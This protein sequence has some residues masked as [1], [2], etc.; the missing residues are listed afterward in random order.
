[1]DNKENNLREKSGKVASIVGI[2]ANIFLAVGKIIVGTIF[3]FMSVLADGLNNLSDCGSSVVSLISFKLSSKP[4]DEE[5]PYGHE[6]IEYISSMIV[7]FLILLIAFELIMEAVGKII[8]P[9]KIEFSYIIIAVLVTSIIIKGLMFLYYRIVTK[10]INSELL[11]A[12]S[13]DCISDCIS[14]TAVLISIIIGKLINYNIDGYISIIVALFIAYSGIGIL[15]D[16]ISHLIG[17]APDEELINQIKTRILNHR[18]VLGIHDLNVYSYGPNKFFASVHIEL[19]AST[20]VLTSHEFIDEIER[21]FLEETNIVLTG[22]HDPIVIN[23]EETNTLRKQI[24]EIVKNININ[25]SM[26]DFRI[27]KA[28]NFTNLIFEVAIPFNTK[29]STEE[30]KNEIKNE[31]LKLSDTYRPVIIVEKQI[32]RQ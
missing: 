26:H 11:K 15:K 3:G 17:Q 7:A 29:K 31:I 9:T 1:M 28:T 4:A 10:K 14:T 21:E 6:R 23:D 20:D 13:I 2:F 16:T 25:F 18:E 32:F 19:D 24:G 27:V 22:H 8:N 5:H 30:I 12:T